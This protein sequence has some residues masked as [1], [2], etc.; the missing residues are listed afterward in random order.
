MQ[1]ENSIMELQN[2]LGVQNIREPI[3]LIQNTEATVEIKWY[4]DI[5]SHMISATVDM[6]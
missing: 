4:V 2:S 5:F 6:P 1:V 3:V